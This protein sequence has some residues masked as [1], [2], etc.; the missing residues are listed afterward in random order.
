MFNNEGCF[1][2]LSWGIETGV[3]GG[4]FGLLLSFLVILGF[5][6]EESG[7]ITKPK[8]KIKN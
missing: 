3:I 1:R 8:K 5:I 2:R 7:A 6:S 4:S